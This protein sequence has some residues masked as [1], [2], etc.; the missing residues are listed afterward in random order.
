MVEK[1]KEGKLYLVSTPIGNLEDI[2][3]RALR[4]LSEVDVILAE[5]TRSAGK[6]LAHHDIAKRRVISFFEG[7]EQRRIAQILQLLNAG[8]TVAL[9]SESGTP[10]VSDPG[11]KLVRVIIEM[12]IALEAVPG[13]TALIAALVVSG[14]P[15]NAFIF[16]GYFPKKETKV[17]KLLEGIKGNSTRLEKVKTAIAYES[18]HRLLRTLYLVKEVFGD[19][20]VVVARE[21][22]KLNE[23]IRREKISQS[24][25]HFNKVK[26]RG[27]FVLLWKLN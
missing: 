20:E 25:I 27:E 22:T 16:L 3:L 9:I 21:L 13:P 24:I 23:E 14:L 7:N 12:G 18:P 8:K 4:V 10:L 2:T 6:L 15:P 17:R 11:F 1:K 26:P 5:D 19:I